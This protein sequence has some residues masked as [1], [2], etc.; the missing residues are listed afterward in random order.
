M[1]TNGEQSPPRGNN[2][3]AG[4]TREVMASPSTSPE[5]VESQRAVAE[6]QAAMAIAKKFPRNPA[7]SMEKILEACSRPSLA[8]Q[9]EYAYPRGGQNVTGPSIR[10]AEAIAQNWGNI[11]FGIRELGQRDERSS[12]QAY[13]WDLETN[14]RSEKVFEV[15][16]VRHTRDKDY[17]LTDPRD[18]YELVANQGAR[19]LRNCILSVIPG[20]VI[21]AALDQVKETMKMQ[22]GAPADQV[23]K[24]LEKFLEFKIVAEHLEARIGHKL[25]SIT[26]AEVLSLR[27]IYNSLKDGYSKPEDWFV[28]NPQKGVRGAKPESAGA[29]YELTPE[30]A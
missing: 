5:I 28:M 25:E 4:Q 30:E 1:K 3:F 24:M 26:I 22:M 17:A 12:V 14:T 6:V 19:R 10:L 8:E 29:D 16:H 2:P 21:D 15:P 11:N 13:A 23:R 9:A 7:E 18:V 27:N 20:D